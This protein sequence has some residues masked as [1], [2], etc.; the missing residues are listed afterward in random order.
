MRRS[1]HRS[2]CCRAWLRGRLQAIGACETADQSRETRWAQVRAE[3]LERG[4]TPPPPPHVYYAPLAR[5]PPLSPEPAAPLYISQG[6]ITAKVSTLPRS[7]DAIAAAV[8]ALRAHQHPLNCSEGRWKA[9]VVGPVWGSKGGEMS[10][11]TF[12][13]LG[14]RHIYYRTC[15]RIAIDLGVPWVPMPAGHDNAPQLLR[16]WSSCTLADLHAHQRRTYMNLHSAY[17]HAH[18]HAYA[19]AQG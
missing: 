9:M 16:S 11:F 7:A 15:L 5:S 4:A 17:A 2:G 6:V 14:S 8:E 3:L 12:A 18:E 13:G 19:H 10:T 1:C